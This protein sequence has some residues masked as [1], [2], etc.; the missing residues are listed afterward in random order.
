[1]TSPRGCGPPSSLIAHFPPSGGGGRREAGAERAPELPALPPPLAAGPALPSLPLLSPSFPSPGSC[2]GWQYRGRCLIRAQLA[3]RDT[4]RPSAL[5]GP[6]MFQ[7]LRGFVLPAAACDGNRD[8][9]SRYANLFRKLDLNEDGRVD[10]AELQTGLR[11]M[12]IPLGKEAEEVKARA[13]GRC[14]AV[15]AGAPRPWGGE[16]EAGPPRSPRDGARRGRGCCVPGSRIRRL[17]AAPGWR[18]PRACRFP[19]PGRCSSARGRAVQAR[20]GL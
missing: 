5:H 20:P 13:R 9:D 6:D 15:S 1:M 10:I 3:G 18:R 16:G 4:V 7:L 19:S 11:A 14:R 12:G 17:G 8:G 2:E